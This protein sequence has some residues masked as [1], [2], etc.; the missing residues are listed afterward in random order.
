MKKK[1]KYI[2]EFDKWESEFTFFRSIKV[3]FGET[4]MFGHLN[5]SSAF[6]YLEEARIEYLKHIG[7]M[8]KYL[9]PN[10]DLMCVAADL[11]CDYLKQVYFDEKISV[12]VKAQT[13]GTSSVDLHYLAKNEKGEACLSGRGALV[14]ISKVTGKGFPWTDKEKELLQSPQ[15]MGLTR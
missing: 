10:S 13:I 11:Q 3:R 9:E 6:I 1:I 4:D 14:Q 12:F 7:L 5:N 15:T 2:D 8:K